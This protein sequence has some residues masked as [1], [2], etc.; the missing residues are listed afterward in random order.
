MR[1][2]SALAE[3]DP[4]ERRDE[5]DERVERAIEE[6]RA[7]RRAAEHFERAVKSAQRRIEADR[8]QH[9]RASAPPHLPQLPR[10]AP[11][12]VAVNVRIAAGLM[13]GARAG[14]HSSTAY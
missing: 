1:A 10:N 4:S 8:L 3:A 6:E 14:V 2:P 7:A 13:A 9:G 11:G 12:S 5:K